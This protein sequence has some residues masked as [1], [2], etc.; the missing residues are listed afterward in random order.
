MT[1]KEKIG[2]AIFIFVVFVGVAICLISAV[3]SYAQRKQ[4]EASYAQAEAL[5]QG[6]EYSEALSVLE[7]LDD[8]YRNV[9][10]L[11]YYSSAHINYDQGNLYRADDDLFQC[12]RSMASD[13]AMPE[14]YE[15]F[16]A[17]V[18]AESAAYAEEQLQK[19][20][21]EY[22]EKVRTGVP[23]VGMSES[24]IANTSL[25]AP[26][27]K[28]GHNLEWVHGERVTTNLYYFYENKRMIFSARCYFGSVKEVWDHRNEPPA[29]NMYY[30]R[31]SSQQQKDEDDPFNAK[32]YLFPEDFYVDHLDDFYD[33]EDAE[34][35]YYDHG[36]K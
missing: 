1:R 23:F 24:D 33:F 4:L 11:R 12:D 2:F 22:R 32:G 16:R 36:G 26:S 5:V 31:K 34:D 9:K 7:G 3:D 15:E 8:S 6:G 17:K 35:Y 10:F 29:L 19:M 20:R 14:G 25:G 21:E 18:A 28:V 27:S 13:E 30:L